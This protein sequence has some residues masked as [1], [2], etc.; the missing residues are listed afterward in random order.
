MK[1]TLDAKNGTVLSVL[2]YCYAI[3]QI[4]ATVPNI[5]QQPVAEVLNKG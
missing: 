3:P 1:V 2:N 5:S 4:S